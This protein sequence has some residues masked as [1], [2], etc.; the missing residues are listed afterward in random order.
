M[1][2]SSM[3]ESPFP[4][5][6][7]PWDDLEADVFSA[8]GWASAANGLP[9]GSYSPLEENSSF[10]DPEINGKFVGGLCSVMILRYHQ[11]PVGPYDEVIWVPGSF[12]VPQLENAH[13]VRIGR[14]YVSSLESTFNGISPSPS[15]S[16]ARV[17][18]M[19]TDIGRRNWNI[20]KQVY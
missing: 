11:T 6:P 10:A 12:E 4:I 7:S 3:A 20:P 15:P 16:S 13:M 17:N 8:V 1:S 9:T 14:I 18:P 5:A 19:L 2:D